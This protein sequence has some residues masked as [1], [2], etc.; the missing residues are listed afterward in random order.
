MQ[1]DRYMMHKLHEL[2]TT[3]R[4]GYSV[5]NFSKGSLTI[6]CARQILILPQ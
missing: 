5:Y 3:V 1:I 2:D 4:K 6:F